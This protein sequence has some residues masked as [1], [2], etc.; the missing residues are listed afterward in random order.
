MSAHCWSDA[1]WIKSRRRSKLVPGAVDVAG[2]GC[3]N[4][5]E[6]QRHGEHGGS[7]CRCRGALTDA[8]SI[9]LR[10]EQKK[11][12]GT[13]NHST[14][15]RSRSLHALRD[16]LFR[17]SINLEGEFSFLVGAS[18]PDARIDQERIQHAVFSVSSVSLWF[19]PLPPCERR[20]GVRKGRPYSRTQSVASERLCSIVQSFV[21]SHPLRRVSTFQL[22]ADG[23]GLRGGFAVKNGSGFS[24]A[25]AQ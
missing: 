24:P 23:L 25:L 15:D 4:T 19:K 3:D 22:R 2:S 7:D 9:S 17:K 6:P 10:I 5:V 12:K 21:L 11:T 16:L 14:F 13:K 20:T 8:R 1:A 18:L